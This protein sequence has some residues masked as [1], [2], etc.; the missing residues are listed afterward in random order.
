MEDSSLQSLGVKGL[1][2]V[3]T[4]DSFSS[5]LYKGHTFYDFVF[6]VLHTKPFLKTDLLS[7]DLL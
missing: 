7:K 4:L 3:D 2:G 1:W 6:A 5:S